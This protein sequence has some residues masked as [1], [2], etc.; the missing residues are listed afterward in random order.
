MFP[1]ALFYLSFLPLI[2]CF[3]VQNISWQTPAFAGL[4]LLFIN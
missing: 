4:T 1:K 3:F 2:N